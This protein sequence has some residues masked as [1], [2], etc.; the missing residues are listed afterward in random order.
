MDV[1]RGCWDRSSLFFS[2]ELPNWC[3]LLTTEDF[4][5]ISPVFCLCSLFLFVSSQDKWN[6]RH[7]WIEIRFITRLSIRQ[8]SP[9]F[10]RASKAWAVENNYKLKLQ[11]Q[12]M[13]V[14]HW[15]C[16]TVKFKF[17]LFLGF[18]WRDLSGLFSYL[19]SLG[20]Q[21][22]LSHATTMISMLVLSLRIQTNS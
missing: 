6:S 9:R 12:G 4:T 16:F 20:N 10:G 11:V 5:V 3:Q 1:N 22:F 2:I 19:S 15:L 7:N 8:R 17:F 21:D 18:Y 14:R 13:W